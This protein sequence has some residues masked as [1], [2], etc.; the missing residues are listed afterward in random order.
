MPPNRVVHA[1]P[2]EGASS[3]FNQGI[4]GGRSDI[5]AEGRTD[6]S[7]AALQRRLAYQ[8]ELRVQMERKK[9]EKEDAKAREKAE[10]ERFEKQLEAERA[11]LDQE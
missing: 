5:T 6:E 3:N 4:R 1:L 8:E 9:K 11:K 7:E 2:Q 10:D